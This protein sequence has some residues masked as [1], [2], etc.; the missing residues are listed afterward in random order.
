MDF[1]YYLLWQFRLCLNNQFTWT[2]GNLGYP[3]GDPCPLCW[4]THSKAQTIPPHGEFSRPPSQL[5]AP[6]SFPPQ[7]TRG[8]AGATN[9]EG[10]VWSGEIGMLPTVR[11][12]CGRERYGCYQDAIYTRYFH[13]DLRWHWWVNGVAVNGWLQRHM[14]PGY[15]SFNEDHKLEFKF[16]PKCSHNWSNK[17]YDI[18]D[19]LKFPTKTNLY[20]LKWRCKTCRGR[21]GFY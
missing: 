16:S 1:V 11:V 2:A 19:S 5:V 10:G 4:Q 17:L 3:V 21:T 20:V 8:D 14:M 6:I 13:T 18:F 12:V 7:H 15:V 9:C